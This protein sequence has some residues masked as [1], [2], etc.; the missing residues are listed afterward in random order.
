MWLKFPDINED[1]KA[2]DAFIIE[3]IRSR[4]KLL[5]DIVRELVEAGGK[6]IRPAFVI[7]SSKFGKYD[8]KKTVKMAAALEIL[9][10]ATL[11][12]D[13]VVDRSKVRRGKTTVTEKYGMDMAVYTGDFLFT[14]AVLAISKGVSVE[15]LGE[16][17]RAVKTI[18]EGEVD[19]YRSR[20]DINTSVM[21]YLKRAGRKTAAL[22]AASCGLGA[23]LAK[24]P[25]QTS[26][27]LAKFGYYYG[28]A[29]QM[30]DDINDYLSDQKSTGK[31][32]GKDILEGVITLPAIYAM[33][34]SKEVRE[35]VYEFIC[36]KEGRSTD[37][38]KKIIAA[39][40]ENG[41]IESTEALLKK[42]VKRGLN[43][44]ER[45]PDNEYRAI[46]TELILA[47]DCSLAPGNTGSTAVKKPMPAMIP[48]I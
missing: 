35:A 41:G 19:Q 42:Y 18:C 7:I 32:V 9:H 37:D 2:V 38:V 25:V 34:N 31:P 23:Y 27:E 5:N 8:R 22:F 12:H 20:N 28:M 26:K 43:C 24:C 46:F 15:R 1:L 11:V 21:T 36:K 17:A 3:N 10:T 47:L 13:D 33:E 6:R 45:L 40:K 29:F 30:R 4:N 14:Q 16:V 44:L 39:I 48:Q